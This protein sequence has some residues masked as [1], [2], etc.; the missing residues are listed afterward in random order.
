[1]KTTILCLFCLSMALNLNAQDLKSLSKSVDEVAETAEKTSLIEK[2]AGDQVQKLT[3]KLN[4]S[5]KQQ[6]QVSDLV[7]S[8]LKTQKFQKLINS[9]SPSQLMGGKAQS[10]IAESLMGS[11]S[12]TSGLDDVLTKDQKKL[13]E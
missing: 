1:M 2:L 8:Q 13:I 11:K 4:L 6:A 7:V 5:E 3:K 9:F 12:F 10:K